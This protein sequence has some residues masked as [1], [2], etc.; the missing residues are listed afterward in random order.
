MS[1]AGSPGDDGRT[2]PTDESTLPLIAH[3]QERDG[4]AWFRD[5]HFAFGLT[6]QGLIAYVEQLDA[7][8][9]IETYELGRRT[10]LVLEGADV[11]EAIAEAS[12]R[13]E[14]RWRRRRGEEFPDLDSR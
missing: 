5:V 8:G 9:E 4:W 3:L 1:N 7:T 2:G 10:L 11:R 13:E 6:E 14:Y 12:D